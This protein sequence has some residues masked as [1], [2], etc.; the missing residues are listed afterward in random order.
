MRVMEDLP[1]HKGL[2]KR[3]IDALKARG[4]TSEAVLEAINKVPRH[5]F[6]D[7][8][9]AHIAYED[10]AFP[11]AAGQTISMPYTVAL[12][13]QLLDIRKGEKI[14]EIGTGSVYQA[15]VLA[16]LGARV[17]TIER[18]KELYD[19]QQ[20]SYPLKSVY[21]NIQFFFGDGFLGLPIYA[22]FHKIIITA[23]APFV[24]PKLVQQLLPG[25]RMVLPI[26]KDGVQFILVIDKAADGSLTETWVEECSF[27]PMLGG[28][29][30]P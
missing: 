7:T 21:K 26:E 24:P 13:T 4:I 25:G 23:A 5:F 1:L 6:F 19:H 12:Q 30:K 29:S 16:E 28:T 8:A 18:Q 27:V 10:R 11:I 20:K 17:F 14:L 15:S 2:R 3:L 22:P 9:L